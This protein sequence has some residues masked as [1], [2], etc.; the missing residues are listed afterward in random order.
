[1]KVAYFDCFS[2]AG[3]DMICAA[4]IDAGAD[5]ER[6]RGIIGS[7]GLSG[8]TL[9]I[10]KV[11]K[12]G[13]AA[14]RFHVALDSQAT[15]PHRHLHHIVKILAAANIPS[16]VRERAERIFTRLAEAEAAVHG[17]TIEKVHFHEVGAVDAIMDVVGA[18]AALDS[19]GIERVECSPI[20]TGSGTVTCS[21]GV[22]PVPAPAT[23]NLLRG[24]PLAPSEETGELTTPTASAILTTLAASYGPPPAMRLH[25]IGYGAG[26]RDGVTR[27]NVLRVLIGTA[28]PAAGDADEVTVL[29][30]NLDDATPET[31]GHCLDVLLQQGALDAWLMPIQ[32]KK[33]RPGVLLTVLCAPADELRMTELVFRETTTFGIRRHRA[34]RAK[35]TRRIETV[36]TAFGPIR[37]KLGTY[38]GVHS[39]KP[40]YEDCRIAAETKGVPLRD[41]LAAAQQAAQRLRDTHAPT[42]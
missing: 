27:P 42:S 32:M 29:E 41:V 17:T 11:K 21:H 9:T 35:M 31:V 24:V 18:V 6:M 36:Q 8:Y 37:V 22:M 14:T 30:T 1:M 38:G 7:L 16:S 23:A 40:E 33:S 26:T 20:P 2:G 28:D 13:F 5:A 19:L 39:A 25:S 3:G 4:L 10:E 12:Q 34:S 15:Q